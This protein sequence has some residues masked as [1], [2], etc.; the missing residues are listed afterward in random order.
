MQ[1][2]HFNADL[3]YTQKAHL[4][5]REC[6]ILTSCLVTWEWYNSRLHQISSVLCSKYLYISF[7]TQTTFAVVCPYACRQTICKKLSCT[8][9]TKTIL[10]YPTN[11]CILISCLKFQKKRT[12]P[13]HFPI[14]TVWLLGGSFW[15]TSSVHRILFRV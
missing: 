13:V 8:K 7:V 5:W 14:R 15:L 2:S 12:F 6:W 4:W 9:Q 11:Y 10:D 1:R 3:R